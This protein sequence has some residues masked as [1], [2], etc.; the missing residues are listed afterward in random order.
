[1]GKA[2]WEGQSFSPPIKP[3]LQEVK[4][5][6]LHHV[7]HLGTGEKIEQGGWTGREKKPK[8]RREVSRRQGHRQ[9]PTPWM[10]TAIPVHS[11]V[12]NAWNSP[13]SVLPVQGWQCVCSCPD[14]PWAFLTPFPHPAPFPELPNTPQPRGMSVGHLDFSHTTFS[15]GV[16]NL[17]DEICPPGGVFSAK[18]KCFVPTAGH[19]NTAEMLI[20]F[21][22]QLLVLSRTTQA[23]NYY[24]PAKPPGLSASL[25]LS[26]QLI[27]SA[28]SQKKLVK[29]IR[30][31]IFVTEINI[32]C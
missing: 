2:A 18:K 30:W 9:E 25:F 1:M 7:C 13:D 21:T 32:Q 11:A 29:I 23:D 14:L 4:E 10:G 6:F 27:P 8:G 17:R 15:E 5:S 24:L 16:S 22:E 19:G 12:R 3:V 31:G 26:F 20:W 28:F